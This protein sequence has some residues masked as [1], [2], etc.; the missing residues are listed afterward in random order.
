[1]AASD[2]DG[3]YRLEN[4]PP[5][6]YII[7]AGFVDRPS[8]YP[9]VAARSNARVVSLLAGA[10]VENIDFA[11]VTSFKVHGRV[12]VLDKEQL[13]AGR[14]TKI[15]LMQEN[16]PAQFAEIDADGRFEFSHVSQ[17]HYGAMVNPGVTM[18]PVHVQVADGD[19]MDLELIVPKTKTISGR[20]VLEGAGRAPPSF[21]FSY[22]AANPPVARNNAFASLNLRD[23]SFRITLPVGILGIVSPV[24][25]AENFS[26]K[27]FTYGTLD[28]LREPLTISASD[29]AEL[30]VV[31]ETR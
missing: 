24:A 17:G 30:R 28:L 21:Q 19:I 27:S 13:R 22:D 16:G 3:V 9:G 11:N 10:I 26:V 7:A 31:L 18:Q 25:P 23:Q 1:L 4:V 5:G 2:A 14:G 12:T 15:R 6:Q 20:I 29:D 8:F